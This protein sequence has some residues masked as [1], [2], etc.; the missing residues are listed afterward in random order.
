[1][2]GSTAN[3]RIP[4]ALQQ[5]FLASQKG[6]DVAKIEAP[7]N[8]LGFKIFRRAWGTKQKKNRVVKAPTASS[9]TT[10]RSGSRVTAADAS[11]K[12]IKQKNAKAVVSMIDSDTFQGETNQENLFF[13]T[14]TN[15]NA[16]FFSFRLT[17]NHRKLTSIESSNREAIP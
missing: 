14:M 8:G 9:L 7:T 10:E 4:A 16:F 3:P 12:A 11:I 5:I 1:M 13:Y 15:I 17:H 6:E 2:A